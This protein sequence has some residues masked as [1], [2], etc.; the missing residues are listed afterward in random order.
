MKRKL[1]LMALLTIV[2]VASTVQAELVGSNLSFENSTNLQPDN[3]TATSL[4]SNGL[5][6]DDFRTWTGDGGASAFDDSSGGSYILLM[7]MNTANVEV[8]RLSQQLTG[9]G[10]EGTY[11]WSL[12]DVGL[13]TFGDDGGGS[14]TYGF[15]L[16]GIDFISGSSANF[17]EGSTYFSP[18]SGSAKTGSVTYNAS[19]SETSLYLMFETGVNAGSVRTV[20]TVGYTEL[21]FQAIPEPATLGLLFAV[22]LITLIR[23]RLLGKG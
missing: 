6:D 10:E 11:T 19:G 12:Y 3:W 2:A 23:R 16:D 15:S 18:S 4:G 9:T 5:E 14:F 21:G 22:G 7:D 1:V 13:A 8:G 17:V 20:S